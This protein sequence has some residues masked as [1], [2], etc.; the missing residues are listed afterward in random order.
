MAT[1]KYDLVVRGSGPAGEKGAAQA[2]YF[3]KKVAMVERDYYLGVAAASTTIPSKTLRESS[4][5]LSGLRARRLHGVDLSLRREVTVQDFLHH[6]S[7]VKDAERTRVVNN[8]LRHGV[9]IFK[10]TGSFCDKRTIKVEA[11]GKAPEFLE[12][13][14]ILIATGSSPRRP[15]NFPI[16]P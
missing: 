7:A 1:H 11:P 15:D 12:G 3:G 16:S 13:D 10:G 2:A 4:L 9:D 8:M 14:V 5:A 6:E